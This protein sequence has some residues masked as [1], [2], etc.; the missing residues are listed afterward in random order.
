MLCFQ[1]SFT[2]LQWKAERRFI[3]LFL[4]YEG[5]APQ[6]TE[7]Q[8]QSMELQQHLMEPQVMATED[9][10][11]GG[12]GKFQIFEPQSNIWDK[13]SER[14]LYFR[15]E[16]EYRSLSDSLELGNNEAS[17]EHNLAGAV[18]PIINR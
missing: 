8:R 3:E 17:L 15:Y 9:R 16:G 11:S 5:M 10:I 7:P 13:I 6:V 12:L 4:L 2:F 18:A 14:L 1:D